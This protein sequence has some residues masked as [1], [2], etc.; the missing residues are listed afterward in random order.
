MN[1]KVIRR[2]AKLERSIEMLESK[3]KSLQKENEDL[4]QI[5]KTQLINR[6][7]QDELIKVLAKRIDELNSFNEKQRFFNKKIGSVERDVALLTKRIQEN[8]SK[9]KIDEKSVSV[10]PSTFDSLGRQYDNGA[11]INRMLDSLKGG[12]S[13]GGSRLG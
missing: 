11:D 8:D 9:N 7:K 1:I 10:N 5:I 4:K 13:I 6:E 12:N 3:L 2:V